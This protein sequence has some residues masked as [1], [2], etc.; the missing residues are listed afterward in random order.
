R[1]GGAQKNKKTKKRGECGKEA[2]GKREGSPTGWTGLAG[3]GR[4]SGG[5][6]LKNARSKMSCVGHAAWQN[7]GGMEEEAEDGRAS[8]QGM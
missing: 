5:K 2:E 7:R 8:K 1:V 6:H 4:E 3:W